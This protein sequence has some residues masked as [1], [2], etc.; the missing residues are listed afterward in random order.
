MRGQLLLIVD[1]V[2]CGLLGGGCASVN[3]DVI[4]EQLGVYVCA[5]P[6]VRRDKSTCSRG[7]HLISL[8]KFG[9]SLGFVGALALVLVG[10]VIYV[11]CRV[12]LFL[13]KPE[14][15]KVDESSGC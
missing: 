3:A 5:K 9:L 7:S 15:F 12:W 11:R 1:D 6:L 13:G 10:R 8:R 14:F 4:S 2:N